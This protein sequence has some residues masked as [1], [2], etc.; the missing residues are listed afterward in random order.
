M[1]AVLI[2]LLLLAQSGGRLPVPEETAQ[3]ESEKLVRNLF[4]TDYKS[5]SPIELKLLARKLLENGQKTD[6]EPANQYV[7]LREAY[8]V[9]VRAGAFDL[10]MEAVTL[11]IRRFQVPNLEL[12]E[13]ALST[14]IKNA[15]VPADWEGVAA[16]CVALAEEAVR[17]NAYATADKMLAQVDGAARRGRS[18]ALIARVQASRDALK[19]IRQEHEKIAKAEQTLAQDPANP[20][21]CAAVG[22]FLCL[23][24][25]DWEGGLP[26]LAQ[27]S[28]ESL[29]TMALKDRQGGKDGLAQAAI[30]EG[31]W[32]VSETQTGSVK[33]GALARALHWYRSSW[34]TLSGIDRE[35]VRARFQKLSRTSTLPPRP[36]SMSTAPKGWRVYDT[37]NPDG[38]FIDEGFARTGSSSLKATPKVNKGFAFM[39]QGIAVQPGKEYVLTAWVL[40]E[41]GGG[42][43]IHTSVEVGGGSSGSAAWSIVAPADQPWWTRIEARIPCSDKATAIRLRLEA[44]KTGSIWLD[45]ISLKEA[46]A[47]AELLVNGSFDER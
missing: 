21:A 18:T 20:D 46:G 26:L 2:T 19:E 17:E 45:D 13:K 22:R 23:I 28:D 42:I 12:A 6:E 16:T 3:K 47:G 38:V 1:S 14:S 8:D 9:G 43:A 29:R 24:K 4:K 11:L 41:G 37:A 27:G 31:W 36:V 40:T 7:L 10:A 25:G 35:R 30:G 39:E 44:P 5:K 15:K 34:P 32:T 33:K